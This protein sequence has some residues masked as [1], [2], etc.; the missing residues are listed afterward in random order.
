[1]TFSPGSTLSSPAPDSPLI[2]LL[3]LA[4]QARD[5]TELA[6]LSFM[7]VNDSHS[8]VPYRQAALW[9]EQGGVQTLSGI[10]QADANVP[11]VQWLDRTCSAL[12]QQGGDARTITA[13]DLPP[14]QADRWDE[15]LPAHGLCVPLIGGGVVLFAREQPWQPQ[16]IALLTEWVD[17]WQHAWKAAAGPQSLPWWRNPM[18]LARKLKPVAGRPWWRQRSLLWVAAVAILL[19]FPVHLTVLAPGELVPSDPT[20]IRAPFDGVIANLLVRPNDLVKKGDPLLTFDDATVATRLNIARQALATAEAELRQVSQQALADAKY[21]S[22][23][24]VLGGKVQERRAEAEYLSGQLERARVFAPRDGV[25]LFDD[26]SEWVG[27]PVSTGERILRVALPDQVEVEAWLPAG[28]A[29]PVEPGSAVTLY[30]NASP[31]SPVTASVRYVAYEAV[32]RPDGNYAYRVRATLDAKTQH[33]VG[34]KGTAKLTGRRVPLAYWA[35]RRPL[36]T[37]RQF[38]GW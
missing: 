9:F 34:L 24:A 27:R 31:L 29:I 6:E 25:A 26:P 5:A 4:R 11:Y 3:A 33:R 14:P 15:W 12:H 17:T 7:L 21:K 1:M 16:E 38:I 22:Q 19:L 18:A 35:L 10:V 32:V 30:L 20:V 8:L 37:V 13:A 2:T 23:L 28:D 36:A